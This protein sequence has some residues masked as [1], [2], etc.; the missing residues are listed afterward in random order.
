MRWRPADERFWEKVTLAGDDACWEWTAAKSS[1]GYGSFNAGDCQ[2][3]SSHRWA[4]EQVVGPIPE[5]LELDHLCRNRACVNPDHLDP[6]THYENIMRGGPGSPG[7]KARQT[8]CKNGHPFSGRNLIV[9]PD[10]QGRAC[11]ACNLAAVHR[12]LARKG[13]V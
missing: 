4:Y 13:V 3:V 10:G 6:V 8:H 1:D 2:I 11:R 9:R 12:Y 7:A 5:G